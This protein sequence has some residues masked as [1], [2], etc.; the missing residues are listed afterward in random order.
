MNGS[1]GKGAGG[2]GTGGAP[3]LSCGVFINEVQVGTSDVPA[4]EFVELYN[5]CNRVTSLA[6]Y[7]LV[8]RAAGGNND[9]LLVAFAA[10]DQIAARSF[11]V[12]GGSA[13]DGAVFARWGGG[14]NGILAA[15]A[16]GVALFAAE[17]GEV[18]ALGYGNASNAFVE[19]AAALAPTLGTSIGRVPDGA[20]TN[21]NWHDFAPTTSSPGSPNH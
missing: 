6:G 7:R 4:D 13:Y 17:S 10:A 2:S 12:L 20:D 15:L 16:G 5:S 11:L 18:D 21:D 3:A 1:G 8:Y 19:G 9:I 14:S